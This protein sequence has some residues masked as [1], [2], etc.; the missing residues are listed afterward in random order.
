MRWALALLFTVT[1]FVTG[2]SQWPR[3]HN[4]DHSTP[5]LFGRSITCVEAESTFE[6][7]YTMAQGLRESAEM[8]DEKHPIYQI[9][10]EMAEA[11][12][13]I[14]GHLNREIDHHCDTES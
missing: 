14:A 11:Y 7:A 1:F 5:Q 3:W 8:F 4:K 13:A 10:S 6:F 12:W 2:M 9:Q